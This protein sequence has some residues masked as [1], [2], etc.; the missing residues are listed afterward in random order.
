MLWLVKL[1]RA[2]VLHVLLSL[3]AAL[4]FFL[5][6]IDGVYPLAT[7]MIHAMQAQAIQDHL[8]GRP[9]GPSGFA[10]VASAVFAATLALSVWISSSSLGRLDSSFRVEEGW[11]L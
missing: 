10:I 3:V 8:Q 1:L 4:A 5:A 9:I 7:D 11:R 2:M 6:G